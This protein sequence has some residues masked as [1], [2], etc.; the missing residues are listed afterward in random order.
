MIVHP[1]AAS[2]RARAAGSRSMSWKPGSLLGIAPISPP[3]WTLF[4]PQSRFRPLPVGTESPRAPEAR[5]PGVG[6]QVVVDVLREVLAEEV[7][8][9]SLLAA[10]DEVLI[11]DAPKQGERRSQH[12]LRQVQPI[13][14]AERA[15][16]HPANTAMNT[17]VSA[18]AHHAGSSVATRPINRRGGERPTRSGRRARPRM[19][20]LDSR[21]SATAAWML[22]PGILPFENGVS[23]TSK[24]PDAVVPT[25][26]I[27][28]EQG[29]IDAGLRSFEDLLLGR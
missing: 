20:R 24:R 8:H 6:H 16:G 19:K 1:H 29:R 9:L 22:S 25:K 12:R 14:G 13:A 15:R 28:A 23:K 27:V 2:N 7:L 3:P 5:K 26:T 10:L 17:A 4:W 18:V 21:S 11:P